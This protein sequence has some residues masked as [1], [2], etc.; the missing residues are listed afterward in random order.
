MPVNYISPIF[1]SANRGAENLKLQPHERN[2]MSRECEVKSLQG[3]CE[4]N[5]VTSSP[6]FSISGKMPSM[7]FLI[8]SKSNFSTMRVWRQ[9]MNLC[10]LII[11]A[12]FWGV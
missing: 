8:N 5:Y 9:N 4:H 7:A 1:S 3:D 11:S 10:S 12:N 2:L 6:Y